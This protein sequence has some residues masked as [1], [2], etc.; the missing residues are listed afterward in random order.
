MTLQGNSMMTALDTA[1]PTGTLGGEV[2]GVDPRR[3]QDDRPAEAWG[4]LCRRSS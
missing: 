2:A 3:R 1:S 4:C